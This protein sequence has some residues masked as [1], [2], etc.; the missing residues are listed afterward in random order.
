[1]HK[2]LRRPAVEAATGLKCSTIYEMIE[3]NAF[4]RPIRVSPGTVAWLESDIRKWQE[5]RLAENG[6]QVA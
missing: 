6:R 2:F 1:M 3:K 4:P 5:A